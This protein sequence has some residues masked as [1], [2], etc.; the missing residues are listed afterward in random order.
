MLGSGRYS[1]SSPSRSRSRSRSRSGSRSESAPLDSDLGDTVYSLPLARIEGLLI[2]PEDFE[3]GDSVTLSDNKLKEEPDVAAW[4]QQGDHLFAK[5]KLPL[6]EIPTFAGGSE[7]AENDL[8]GQMPGSCPRCSSKNWNY[9][10]N[11]TVVGP[12]ASGIVCDFYACGKCGCLTYQSWSR[13]FD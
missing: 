5:C 11:H 12:T 9:K 1:P 13:S 2:K 8:E 10:G 3:I 6:S 4:I 7:G